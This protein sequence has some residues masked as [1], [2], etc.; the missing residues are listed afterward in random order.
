MLQEQAMANVYCSEL[1]AEI[2]KGNRFASIPL[3]H[4]LFPNLPS[5]EISV[6]VSLM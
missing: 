6:F 1:L 2:F 3:F 4:T 5:M